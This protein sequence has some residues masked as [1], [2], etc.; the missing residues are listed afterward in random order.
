[1]KN[2]KKLKVK[3]ILFDLDGTIV[4]SR[5]AYWEALKK[6]FAVFGQKC[7]SR[8][9]MMEIPRRLEQNMSLN[10]ILQ[11]VDVQQFL[12]VYLKAYYEATMEKT[13]P[14]PGILDT[15]EKLSKKA[16]LSVITM[17]YVPKEKVIQELERFGL[18]KY[19][20][21][22]MTALNTNEPKPSPEA[23]VKCSN[24]MGI[25]TCRCAFVGDSVI[26]VRAG[27]A[28]GTRTVAVLSGIFSLEELKRENPDLIL[29]NVNR[30]PDFVE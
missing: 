25:P 28:A 13:K 20:H 16:K 23:L 6:A 17:R 14:L 15:L 8:N 7:F 29:E 10:D 2:S 5:E 3:G 30:L 11:E 21:E 26:D 1:M 24:R 12:E 18:V 22:V 27:K 19:F 4:D 9:M